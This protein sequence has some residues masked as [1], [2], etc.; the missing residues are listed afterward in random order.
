MRPELVFITLRS[1]KTSIHVNIH[2]SG[3]QSKKTHLIATQALQVLS[4][5]SQPDIAVDTRVRVGVATP[6]GQVV[7]TQPP[8]KRVENHSGG[9]IPAI[10]VEPGTPVPVRARRPK[11]N[12]GLQ[13]QDGLRV[14]NHSGGGTWAS[15]HARLLLL[16]CTVPVAWARTFHQVRVLCGAQLVDRY[17]VGTQTRPEVV[18][19]LRRTV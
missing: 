11:Q 18:V 16:A 2:T 9:G 13:R 6:V 5:A 8:G 10:R 17:A 3:I 15:I 14:A 12:G 1:C 7:P 19:P 4:T